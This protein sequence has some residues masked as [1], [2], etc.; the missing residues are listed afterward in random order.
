[1]QRL[2]DWLL[3]L[4]ETTGHPAQSSLGILSPIFNTS[5]GCSALGTVWVTSYLPSRMYSC[6]SKQF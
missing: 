1:M 6:S 5:P 2:D 4:D 3:M